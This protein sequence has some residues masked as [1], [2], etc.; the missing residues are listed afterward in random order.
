M[1]F[2]EGNH[3]LIAGTVWKVRRSCM[4]GGREGF[5]PK[6]PLPYTTYHHVLKDLESFSP[7]VV[8]VGEGK[9]NQPFPSPT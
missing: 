3:F 5:V 4:V 2:F 1:V 6:E 9:G 7:V 8:A